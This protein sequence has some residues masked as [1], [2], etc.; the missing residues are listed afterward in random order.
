[1]TLPLPSNVWQLN[2]P[3]APDT[4]PLTGS[5]RAAVAIVGGG[6]VGPME[7]ILQD[8]R[9]AN[10]ID[11]VSDWLRSTTGMVLADVMEVARKELGIATPEK[12]ESGERLPRCRAG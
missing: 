5:R 4:P 8:I 1:M 12:K 6:I 7:G 3:A 10:E 11:D 9:R 2:A